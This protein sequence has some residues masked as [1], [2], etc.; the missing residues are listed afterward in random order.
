MS[1]RFQQI[2]EVMNGDDDIEDVATAPRLMLTEKQVLELVPVARSTLQRYVADGAFPAPVQI[3]PNQQAW[4]AD[5]I[6]DWQDELAAQRKPP[7]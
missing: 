1:A 3:G 6:A 2:A 4:F 5:E 7:R